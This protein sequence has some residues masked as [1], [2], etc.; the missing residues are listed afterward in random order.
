MRDHTCFPREKST[1]RIKNPISTDHY[2]NHWRLYTYMYRLIESN[3]EELGEEAFGVIRS[4]KLHLQDKLPERFA[5]L[6]RRF[7]TVSLLLHE[8]IEIF[9]WRTESGSYHN[10]V[11]C[12]NMLKQRNKIR[13]A[14]DISP[15]EFF[16]RSSTLRKARTSWTTT[17]VEVCPTL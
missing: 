13:H 2:G 17:D 15:L 4:S 10:V 3:L 5:R 14:W 8:R 11:T 12:L 6:K 16:G 9:V 1:N 7:K